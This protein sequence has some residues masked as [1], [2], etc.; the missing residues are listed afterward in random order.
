MNAPSHAGQH[1][2]AKTCR[3]FSDPLFT[4]ELEADCDASHLHA[5][6]FLT[7]NQLFK[8]LPSAAEEGALLETLLSA[9]GIS[10]EHF[11][12]ERATARELLKAGVPPWILHIATHAFYV[13]GK[14]VDLDGDE[15]K[16]LADLRGIPERRAWSV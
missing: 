12:G 3:I 7:R 15:C 8:Q 16:C 1:D 6:T 13:P 9:A 14:E 10:V 11:A 2:G 5:A 4:A